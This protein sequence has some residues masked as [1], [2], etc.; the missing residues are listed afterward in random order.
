[1]K[2]KYWMTKDPVTI[3]PDDLIV[4]AARLMKERGFRRLPVMDGG[5]LVGL[6]T[7]RNILEA[8]PSSVSTLSR[9]EARYLINKMKV[10]DVM[11]KNPVTVSP[12]DDVILAM[13]EGNRRGLGCYP[14]VAK[15]NLVGIVTATDLFNLVT[16]VLGAVDRDDFVYVADKTEKL[17]DPHYLPRVLSLLAGHGI[18]VF[19]FLIFPQKEMIENSVVLLKVTTGRRAEALDVLIASGFQCLDF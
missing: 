9:Q 11:R 1:M 6:V 19:S 7:Y 18:A 14:V 10:S 3:G 2:V 13:M 4:G 8:Q 17:Q 12:E 16:H 5:R 15:G